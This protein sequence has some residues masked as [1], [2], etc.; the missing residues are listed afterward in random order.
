MRPGGVQY[1]QEIEINVAVTSTSSDG[2]KTGLH[3]IESLSS[4]DNSNS[5]DINKSCA[6]TIK[7]KIPVA[8]PTTDIQE[9]QK[10][11][12]YSF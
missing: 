1:I 9:N 4:G 10:G 12:K 3:V 8:L 11:D 6:N 7:L 5:N 2:S